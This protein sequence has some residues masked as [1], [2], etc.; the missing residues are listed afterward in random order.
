MPSGKHGGFPSLVEESSGF[1]DAKNPIEWWCLEHDSHV[2]EWFDAVCTAPLWLIRC[3][4][5]PFLPF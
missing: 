1:A 4:L 5:V 2:S 3:I